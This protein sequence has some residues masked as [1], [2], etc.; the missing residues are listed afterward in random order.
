MSVELWRV[1]CRGAD[2]DVLAQYAPV[3]DHRRDAVANEP[4]VTCAHS[5]RAGLDCRVR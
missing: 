3:P 2:R 4:N 1:A 5:V